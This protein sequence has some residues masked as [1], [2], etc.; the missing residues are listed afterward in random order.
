MKY[1]KESKKLSFEVAVI[2]RIRF[3][4]STFIPF[5]NAISWKVIESTFIIEE[6]Y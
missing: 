1:E 4:K 3:R 2:H 5:Y 6:W